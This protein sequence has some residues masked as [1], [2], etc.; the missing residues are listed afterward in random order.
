MDKPGV[1]IHHLVLTFRVHEEDGQFASFCE[2]LGIHSAG[3]TVDEA[4]NN[5]VDATVLY[6]N[7]LENT[8]QRRRVFDELNIPF[9]RGLPPD[10]T[11]DEPKQVAPNEM[12]VYKKR[13]APV[14]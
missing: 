9:D 4:L 13:L 3:D 6:L 7:Y 12:A 14:G 10:V 5:S 11:P 1:E 8:G 2:E